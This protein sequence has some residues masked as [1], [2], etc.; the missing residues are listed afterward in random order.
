[1]SEMGTQL[2]RAA[3]AYR[4]ERYLGDLAADVAAELECPAAPAPMLRLVS[5][6]APAKPKGLR[7]LLLLGALAASSSVAAAAAL[8]LWSRVSMLPLTDP[9]KVLQQVAERT[10]PDLRVP[11]VPGLPR[12]LGLTTALA[13]AWGAP[14]EG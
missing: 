9:A 8:L 11:A 1:M 12:H 6:T 10:L 2:R 13:P 5:P 7:R 3:E 4:A 14:D